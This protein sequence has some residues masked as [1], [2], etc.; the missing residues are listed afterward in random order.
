MVVVAVKKLKVFNA[1]RQS[2][3]EQLLQ[4]SPVSSPKQ[5]Q[6]SQLTSLADASQRLAHEATIWL[7]LHNEF[8]LK[9]Y[10]YRSSPEA[11]LVSPWSETGN[12]KKFLDER[13]PA[14]HRLSLVSP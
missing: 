2:H 13:P 1:D 5:Y 6:T 8:I 10:G 4:V 11:I 3:E 9:L 7:G 14:A 12:L